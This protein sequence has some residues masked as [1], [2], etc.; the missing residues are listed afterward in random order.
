MKSFKLLETRGGNAKIKKSQK[1]SEYKIASLSL[2]PD[3]LIC[4]ARN[5]AQCAK[6]CLKFSGLADVFKS[7]NQSRKMKTEL[8]HND[9]GQFLERLR[10]EIAAFERKCAR[11]GF[12]AAFRLNTISDI[13][14]ERFEIPQE[15]SDSLFFDYTKLAARL[16][17]TPANYKLMFSYSAAPKYQKAVSRALQTNVPISAVFRGGNPK[18]FIGRPVVN[19][20]LS[21]L[22]NVFAGAVVLGLRLKG[23]KRIQMLKDMLI[24][25]NPELIETKP[26]YRLAA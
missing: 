20:D 23:P 2:Y 5:L 11:D 1:D 6:P 18:S 17:N 14:Y 4:P 3:D 26:R 19:G 13:Q 21:D 16:G 15:F 12:K 8:W 10:K 9:P 7:V 22:D 24:V 25:D